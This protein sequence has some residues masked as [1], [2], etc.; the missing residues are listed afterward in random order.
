MP[1][2]HWGPAVRLLTGFTMPERTKLFDDQKGGD[3]SSTPM[4]NVRVK[5]LGGGVLPPEEMGSDGSGNH[6]T[7]YAYKDRGGTLYLHRISIDFLWDVN[8]GPARP[9]SNL[10][11]YILGPLPMLINL[12]YPPH[13]TRGLAFDGTAVEDINSVVLESFSEAAGAWDRAAQFFKD[14]AA[15]L[16]EWHDSLNRAD[17]AWQGTAAGAFR[18]VLDT[19]AKNENAYH[20]QL[21][22]Q[23]FGGTHDALFPVHGRPRSVT[24]QGDALITAQHTVQQAAYQMLAAWQ[25]WAAHP[26]SN[27][28]HVLHTQVHGLANWLLDHNIS[29]V[30][31]YQQYNTTGAGNLERE[32]V[33]AG[34]GFQDSVSDWGDL[35]ETAT[36]ARIGQWSAD[37]WAQTVDSMLSPVGQLQTSTVN[38]AFI[39]ASDALSMQVTTRHTGD[40]K[41]TGNIREEANKARADLKKDLGA[42]GGG[43]GEGGP[44]VDT[45]SLGADGA[46]GSGGGEDGTGGG[47]GGIRTDVSG[48]KGLPDSVGGG[49]GGGGAAQGA[50]G[51]GGA[52]ARGAGGGGSGAPG[53]DPAEIASDAAGGAGSLTVATGHDGTSLQ[54]AGSG[55]G[56]AGLSG[57]P[58]L[59][60]M[61]G[62]VTGA[63][64]GRPGRDD[65]TTVVTSPGTG[66]TGGGGKSPAG[67]P[68]RNSDGS[69][70]VTYAD[71]SKV[72]TWPDGT[73]VTTSPDGTTVR[74]NPDGS[75]VA[76]DSD[77]SQI[78]TA[79]DG[80]VTSV[81]SD[82]TETVR[83]PDG[84]LSVTRPDGVTTITGRDGSVTTVQPDG[85]SV[86]KHPGGLTTV[87]D[88]NGHSSVHGPDGSPLF[89]VKETRLTTGHVPGSVSEA[90]GAGGGA[91]H[92]GSG[93]GAGT[94]GSGGGLRVPDYQ[95]DGYDVATD[96]GDYGGTGD[97]GRTGGGF[98]GAGM[99][100]AAVAAAAH[101]GGMGMGALGMPGMGMGGGAAGALGADRMREVMGDAGASGGR[102]GQAGGPASAASSGMPFMP[103]GGAPGGGQGTESKDRER[104]NWMAEEEDVWGVETDGNPAV[105]GRVEQVPAATQNRYMTGE[106]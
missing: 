52:G 60:G 69:S 10:Y 41:T 27:P 70:T 61:P 4:M 97:E 38:N 8:S 94:G 51:L 13:S 91:G 16:K 66:L 7:L 56:G 46:G 9:G 88:K 62:G 5:Q 12:A 82:G 86:T 23:G 98:T 49:A 11:K 36:W 25:N 101:A 104:T 18:T 79:A 48:I 71:G 92:G 72:T 44:D 28:L 81:A 33:G 106:R 89:P 29:Q 40:A 63:Q 67:G 37:F 19:A 1:D 93:N 6:W 14:R 45:G 95:D 2:D 80:T 65:T 75:S 30:L 24:R 57:L 68:V 42:D 20:D 77:G 53:I 15:D 35:T 22:P 59:P 34:P 83:R 87:T 43:G 100:P 74:D 102:A 85:S 55:G 78:T 73:T 96:F 21:S 58:G 99:D 90:A 76:I 32:Y 26:N 105:I 64:G 47:S 17:A 50:D 103:P 84:T 3:D 54:G 31:H 39:Q